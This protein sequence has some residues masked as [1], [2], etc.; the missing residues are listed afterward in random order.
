[1]N[2]VYLPSWVYDD[3]GLGLLLSTEVEV[4]RCVLYPLSRETHYVVKP[5]T[6]VARESAL[7]RNPKQGEIQECWQEGIR[8]AR[9]KEWLTLAR[10]FARSD[11]I[12]GIIMYTLAGADRIQGR[13]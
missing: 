13:P 4:W 6:E 5:W 7:Y 3:V 8:V 2:W 10:R 1:M 12:I 11:A 9:R